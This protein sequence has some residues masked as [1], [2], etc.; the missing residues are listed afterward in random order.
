MRQRRH[1]FSLPGG[2]GEERAGEILALEFEIAKRGTRRFSLIA[3]QIRQRAGKKRAAAQ[4]NPRIDMR[5]RRLRRKAQQRDI[6]ESHRSRPNPPAS[7][8]A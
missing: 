3:N 8:S 1:V 6:F 4:K 5:R 2:E 7:A